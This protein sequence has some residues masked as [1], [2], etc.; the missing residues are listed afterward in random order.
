[1]SFFTVFQR[2]HTGYAWPHTMSKVML[3]VWMYSKWHNFF[4]LF[5]N[6]HHFHLFITQRCDYVQS[7]K[8]W[9]ISTLNYLYNCKMSVFYRHLVKQPQST[10][11]YRVTYLRFLKISL[12]L[13]LT[14]CDHVI[15][16][17]KKPLN[18]IVF[19][20]SSGRSRTTGTTSTWRCT[21]PCTSLGSPRR[22]A[23][24][25]SSS[26]TFATP[27]ASTVGIRASIPFV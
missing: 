24:R 15:L 16:C 26:G 9:N 11:L 14:V 5:Y 17:H 22:L 8:F 3:L 12:C 21:T 23:R 19:L 2:L 25:R 7:V 6:R 1:M 20:L 27:P 18:I 13:V 10:V 4:S